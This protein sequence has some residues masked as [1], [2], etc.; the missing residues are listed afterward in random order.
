[1]NLPLTV[2]QAQL[3]EVLLNVGLGRSLSGAHPESES[4]PSLKILPR[5]WVSP[6]SA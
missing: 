2:D 6:V 4:P 3:K 1:M 5:N